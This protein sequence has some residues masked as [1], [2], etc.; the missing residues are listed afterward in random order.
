M[1]CPTGLTPLIDGDILRYEIGRGA[2][3]G[4]R[5]IVN[6]EDALPPFNYVEGMLLSRI[7][8]IQYQVGT[9]K[10]PI[11]YLTEGRTFRYD[12][13]VRRKYKEHRKTEKPFHFHNLTVYMRDVLGAKIVTGIEA[14]DQLAIDH[15]SSGE[16]T[17][18]CS[19][20]KDLKQVP[21]WFYSWEL[22]AQPSFG[23]EKI[24]Q[25]GYLN[26]SPN[27]KKVTGTGL[28]FF[29]SQML[30][31]DITDNIP[32][33]Q[34]IGPV[35]A[36]NLLV[37]KTREEQFATVCEAYKATYGDTWETEMTEQGQL[38]W[39]LRRPDDLWKMGMIE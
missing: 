27:R 7:E 2:E 3:Q 37:D 20:D 1:I 30:T 36:Y 5:A 22:G 13:A 21:G 17:I 18:L 14:D 39:L 19:R 24:T 38:C 6:E 34:G 15:L 31:G 10:D 35:A 12:I 26:L 4:W 16:T 25:D 9:H 28:A 23:P 8:A 33:I 29:Y 11:L 32:G